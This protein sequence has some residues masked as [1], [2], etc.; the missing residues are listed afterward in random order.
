MSDRTKQAGLISG[1]DSFR[2][3]IKT[4]IGI[5]LA[6]LLS[7]GDYGSYRQLFLIYT[8]FSALLLLGIPQSLLY[9]LP[10]A[11]NEQEQRKII[12]RTVN[13]ISVLGII[14]AA[15]LMLLRGSIAVLLNNP[16]LKNLLVIYAVYPIMLFVTQL[17]SSIMLGLGKVANAAR[18]TIFAIFCDAVVVLGVAWFSRDLVWIT[19]AVVVSAMLQWLYVQI[20]LRK[21]LSVIEFDYSGLKMQMRYCLPLGLSSIIGVLTIQLD[22]FVISGYFSPEQF[23]IFSVGAMELP[24]IG[25]LTNSVNAVLLPALSKAVGSGEAKR[26]SEQTSEALLIYRA[27]IRKN[28]LI[29]FPLSIFCFLYARQI[30]TFLYSEQYMAS[31]FYFRIYLFSVIV[32]F[33]SY[34]IIFQAFN[35]TKVILYNSILVL[36]ANLALN[37]IL[38][39]RMGMA[40]PALATVCITYISIAAYL[41]FMKYNLG[42]SLKA[43]FPVLQLWKTIIAGFGAG[44]LLWLLPSWTSNLV[45]AL[46]S[47]AVLFFAVFLILAYGVGAVLPYDVSVVMDSLKA[48]RKRVWG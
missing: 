17:Y 36:V 31:A 43:I 40:G 9:F 6:R 10:K 21:F 32:R 14:F 34:G 22:K 11:G 3:L 27:S 28:A 16:E 37:L 46:S 13:L 41:L 25:I 7:P 26:S 12:A 35:R 47:G 23:A 18:F 20:E 29:I 1:A 2:F 4:V 38:V 19:S 5:V 15:A 45:L 39:R 24:F 42:L 33:A 30:I 8:S 44:L 48:I